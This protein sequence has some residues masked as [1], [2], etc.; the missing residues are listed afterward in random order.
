MR[1]LVG[2]AAVLGSLAWLTATGITGTIAWRAVAVLDADAATTGVLSASEVE[3]ALGAARTAA[4]A[5]PSTPTASAPIAVPPADPGSPAD[6]EIARTWAV[7]GGTV[8]AACTGSRIALLYA[9]PSD[10]W[11]VEVHSS[12]PEEIEVELHRGEQELVVRATCVGGEPVQRVEDG[13][14]EGTHAPS[15]A[16]STPAGA[17]PGVVPTPRESESPDEHGE[18]ESESPTPDPSPSESRR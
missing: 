17:T 1:A 11:T 6:V 9:T 2:R 16:P 4:A 13:S 7:A 8:A 18:D 10:G 5:R 15:T 14:D 12:G 3:A